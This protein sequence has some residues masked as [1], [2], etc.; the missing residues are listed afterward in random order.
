MSTAARKRLLKDFKRLQKDC[1]EGIEASP[2]GSDIMHWRAV[3]I[4]PNETPWEG[5]VFRLQLEFTEDYPN[6]PPTVQ[7]ESRIFHPNVYT[8]GKVCL[9][10]LKSQ[11]SAIYDV[12][13]ILICCRSL[14]S[15]PNPASPANP[16]AAAMFESDRREYL[17][18][19][20]LA[21]EE[22]WRTDDGEIDEDVD[23]DAD[24]DAES[25]KDLKTGGGVSSADAGTACSSNC[26]ARESVNTAF[27]AGIAAGAGHKSGDEPA[28]SSGSAP[29]NVSKE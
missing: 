11:W 14:L 20:R 3:V 29:P 7:F 1:P 15:D 16:E 4:G 17:R 25:G 21:V 12:M 24:A 8:N 13:S 22:S 18:R 28:A 5:G 23:A 27:A 26:D 6:V 9:D 10:V 19:V 2:S